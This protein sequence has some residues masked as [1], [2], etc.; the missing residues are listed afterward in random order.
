MKKLLIFSWQHLWSIRNGAGAPSYHHTIMHYVNSPEW[1]I[2]IFTTD[3]TNL[4]LDIAKENK[5][6]LYR[7]PKFIDIGV[8]K[9]KINIIFRYLKHKLYT[10]WAVR[11][12]QKVIGKHEEVYAYGYEVWGVKAAQKVSQNYG[13]PLITRFQGTVLCDQND[14]SI[15]KVRWYPHYGALS[16]LADLVIMT[17]D[18][19][20]G[21]EVLR[22]LGNNSPCLFIRNGLDLYASY[23]EIMTNTDIHAVKKELGFKEEE[24]II[25]MC[26]RLASWK[27]VDRG[28]TALSE[29]LKYRKDVK[30]MLAGDGDMRLAL[31]EQARALGIEEHVI[32]LGSVLHKDLYRYMLVADLFMSLYDMGNLGNPTFEAMMLKRP[33]IAL[34]NGA[35]ST[36]LHHGENSMLC[37]IDKLAELPNI[38]LDLLEKDEERDRIASSAYEYAVK[39]FYTWEERMNREEQRLLAILH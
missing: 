35:T 25:M 17:D 18:G 36:V 24:K 22:R 32:F 3:E 37:D 26:S 31:E 6:F 12:A 8:K 2:Y 14:T 7:A 21:D 19:T 28:I 33:I 1:D 13:V 10:Q 16:T 5:V 20:Y 4:E 29:V 11:K 38:I 9:K 15:N 39:N 34:N 30:L 27:R 23:K